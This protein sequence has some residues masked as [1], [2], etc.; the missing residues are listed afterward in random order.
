MA[1]TI[2]R[3]GD[4]PG[5]SK[6]KAL[7]YG[8]SGA[9]KTHFGAT[10]KNPI[11]AV[12][13]KQAISVI[14]AINPNAA[15]AV[16][17]EPNDLLELISHLKSLIATG[18]CP[19][20]TLV[21]DSV[22]E[23]Q[24]ILKTKKIRDGGDAKENLTQTEWMIV[25]DRTFNVSRAIRDL[26]MHIL[27]LA[28]SVTVA[29]EEDIPASTHPA[30]N[31]KNLHTDMASIVNIEGFLAKKILD[32]GRVVHAIAFDAPSGFDSKGHRSL[33]K[34]VMPHWPHIVA[35]VAGPSALGAELLDTAEK[36]L[37][38]G[39]E[40]L[41]SAG[42]LAE[43]SANKAAPGAAAAQVHVAAVAPEVS[44][45]TEPKVDKPAAPA[46]EKTAKK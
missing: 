17:E 7:V 13:E 21:V 46:V 30:F 3:A 18:K 24:R 8:K 39:I 9:G 14:Q 41:K 40:P 25:I 27:L 4:H 32:D 23:Y 42:V 19:Y 1:L 20:D 44:K 2:T 11:I 28:L 12:C 31:G 35:C 29:G 15:I 22:S 45:S 33:A 34:V 16:I 38:F 43:M 5:A 6:V 26:D 10:A 36:Q 37:G